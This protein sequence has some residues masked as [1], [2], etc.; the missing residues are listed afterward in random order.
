MIVSLIADI[1]VYQLSYTYYVRNYN[2]DLK[3]INLA[4][5]VLEACNFTAYT[6]FNLA[7]WFFAFSY[8]VLSYRMELTAKKL[9]ADTHNCRLNTLN[10]LVCLFNVILPAIV[11]IYQAKEKYKAAFIAN[12]IE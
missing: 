6:T 7:H 1:V 4:N 3:H 2:G 12:D 10:I 9:P 11:W 5:Q 8:L